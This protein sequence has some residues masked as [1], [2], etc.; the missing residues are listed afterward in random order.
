MP[1]GAW[2]TVRDLVRIRQSFW[3]WNLFLNEMGLAAQ[4]TGRYIEPNEWNSWE[5]S[6]PPLLDVLSNACFGSVQVIIDMTI[7]A[8][9]VG[10]R[11]EIGAAYR[12]DV[13]LIG[14]TDN[15]MSVCVVELK[16]WTGVRSIRNWYSYV[17]TSDG[18]RRLHPLL[19]LFNQISA[20]DA[21]HKNVTPLNRYRFWGTVFMH[22]ERDRL[23]W[24]LGLDYRPP[25]V[26][27][28]PIFTGR[29]H[30]ELSLFLQNELLPVDI[31]ADATND[32]VYPPWNPI[33]GTQ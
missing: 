4:D 2:S 28:F 16:Q 6:L 13:I 1:C 25:Y 15:S 14:G 17:R 29:Q 21:F 18:Q 19:Q 9:K 33:H 7:P 5:I 27:S 10:E 32:F 20:L 22:E 31:R 30:K 3:E 26:P 11:T 24:Q 12:P 23:G 8:N